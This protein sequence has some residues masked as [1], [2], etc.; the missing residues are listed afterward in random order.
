MIRI[1]LIVALTTALGGCGWFDRSAEERLVGERISVLK[2]ERSL[3]PDASIADLTIRLPKPV[4]NREWPQSGG[5]P[6]HAMHHLAFGNSPSRLWR[7][8]IG[9]GSNSERRLVT[10]PVVANDRVYAMDASA[11]VGAYSAET[12][13][14]FW[15][16]DLRPKSETE[17]TLGG[18]LAFY[19]GRL[20]VT[21]GFAQVIALDGDSGKEIWR[22]DVS[23]PMRAPPTANSGRILVVTI[24]NKTH[25]LAADDG[26]LLWS[27]SG[28]PEVA[29]FLGA[30]APAVAQG[31]V[32]VPY[33][34][35]ELFALR[36]TD[37]ERLWMDFLALPQR[38]SAV[39]TIADIRGAPVIDRGRVFA[40]S[41]SG[42][43]VA[44]NLRTGSRVWQQRLS[45]RQSPWVAG[46]YVYQVT[47]DGDLLCLSRSDG[48]VR[49]VRSLPIFENARRKTGLISWAGPVLV[50]DRL[51]L[52]G[53]H[54][55]VLAISPYSGDL[56]GRIKMPDGMFVPP[57][58]ANRTLYFLTDDADLIALR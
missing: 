49:W 22:R 34:S 47:V 14:R 28:S 17:G 37:G 27:H 24:D 8:N 38:T 9:R 19:N 58:I 13:Q 26:R 4:V 7:R 30:A 5:Y 43:M 11:R 21:T 56:L 32:V 54:G 18:G 48:R 23:G 52:A 12:G 46:D 33:S 45:G 1:C 51:V 29:G 41:N 2:Y 42:R 39:L 31:I 36:L 50:G 10:Q 55:E 44:I 53:S 20:Y 35:G 25:A 3:Q 57:V 40:I 6:N 16:R 15:R